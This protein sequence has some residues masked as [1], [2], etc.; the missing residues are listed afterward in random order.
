VKEIEDER[1]K[2]Q[3]QR[4]RMEIAKTLQSKNA[5]DSGISRAEIDAA[6]HYA[7]VRQRLCLPASPCSLFCVPQVKL[8]S[9]VVK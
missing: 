8:L 5:D 3:E 4:A 6:V 7:Q 2:L 1:Q 9:L